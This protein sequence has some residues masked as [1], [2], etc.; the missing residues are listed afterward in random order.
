MKKKIYIPIILLLLIPSMGC[1]NL[2]KIK[3]S[4][5]ITGTRYS[6]Q[7][8]TQSKHIISARYPI[9]NTL[10]I[11][12]SVSQQSKTGPLIGPE[13]PDYGETSLEVIF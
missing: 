4:G 2:N 9:S 12:G 10:N 13:L 3:I 11:K 1:E 7:Q 6:N 8:F 5:E